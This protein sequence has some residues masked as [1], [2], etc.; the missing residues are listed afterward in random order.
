MLI[1]QTTVNEDKA[2][3][4]QYP[5]SLVSLVIDFILST[6]SFRAVERIF[7]IIKNSA[8]PIFQFFNFQPSWKSAELWFL[9]IGLYKLTRVKEKAKDWIVILDFKVQAGRQKC[10]I[11]LGV[12]LST[13]VNKFKERGSFDIHHEDFEPLAVMPVDSANGQ[14]VG[15]VLEDI[16][17]MTGEFLQLIADHGSDVN[18]GVRLYCSNH[19]STVNTY[20]TMHKVAIL[21]KNELEKD[22]VWKEIIRLITETKQTTKQSSE[23][24]LS[25]PKQREKARFMNAD[26][27]IDW[28]QEMLDF[29]ITSP[30]VAYLD[31][32]KIKEKL[33]WVLEFEDII[34]EYILMI[35]II[36][37]ARHQIRTEGLHRG[38]QVIFFRKLRN[39][40]KSLRG[41]PLNLA[42]EIIKFFKKEGMQIPAGKI[43]I[44]SSEGIESVIGRQKTIAERTKATNSITKNVLGIA[45]MVGAS[46]PALVKEALEAI[47]VKMLEEWEDQWIGKSDLSKRREI[48]C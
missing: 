32:N 46:G 42:K 7:L 8:I 20:D 30:E 22:D 31:R 10:L 38:T 33:G 13:L 44:G 23:A 27:L 24:C 26:I 34:E 18:K 36:R 1:A 37:L 21:L 40:Y 28:L 6:I 5:T 41:R 2:K 16:S 9:R 29:M 4:H 43:F 47:S 48:F 14:H 39:Q 35:E 12:R 15:Q 19:S 17:K 25:P 3:Q 11:I 45:A